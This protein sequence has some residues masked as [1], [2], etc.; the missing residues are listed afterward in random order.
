[1]KNQK[2]KIKNQN[3]K[4]VIASPDLSERSNLMRLLRRFTSRNDSQFSFYYLL[5]TI[6]YL[7]VTSAFGVTTSFWKIT[8]FKECKLENIEIEDGI[9]SPGRKIEPLWDNIEVY[10]WAIFPYKNC[11]YIGTGDE[12]K[13]YKLKDNKTS[14]LFDTKETGVLSLAVFK[15]DI[16]IGTASN[17]IIFK[18]DKNGNS[19]IFKE[20]EQEYI[21][22]IVFDEKGNLY[23][24]TGTQGKILKI[25]R[26][27]KMEVFYETGT[28][29][30][31]FLRYKNGTFYAGT[32]EDGL[33]FKI[34]KTGTGRCIYDA[35]EDEIFGIIPT[36]TAI[37]FAA[38]SD[39]SSSIYKLSKN[40]T[41]EKIWHISTT[42][43]GLTDELLCAADNRLYEIKGLNKDRLIHEFDGEISCLTKNFIGTSKIG[44][45]YKL[46]DSYVKQGTLTSP[47]YEV[48]GVAKWGKLSF[49][50]K[51]DIIFETSSGNIKKSEKTWEQWRKIEEQGNIKS[52]SA[53]FIK[54][55]AT[56]KAK[57]CG[58]KE[59]CVS[60]LPQNE[61]PRI[62]DITITTSE[63]NKG[64][65]NI[66][67]KAQDPNDDKL[68]F[69]LY[70]KSKDSKKW[71]TIK[72][73]ISDTFYLIDKSSF[74][75]GDYYFKVSASD[76]PSNPPEHS[77]TGSKISEPYL[78]DN[79]PPVIKIRKSGK[80][81]YFNVIDK[82]S[83]I[84]SF[85]YSL[86]GAKW[87]LLFP[88][89]GIFDSKQERFEIDISKTTT[90]VI[91]AEDSEGNIAFAREN[92]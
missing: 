44:K 45:L 17:G 49:E 35:P 29:N 69:N 62:E 19:S 50:G 55:R 74:P 33:V 4:F 23:A 37:F 18:I 16:Y 73:E 84:K 21:W 42:I 79:T 90:L 20:T 2:S 81:L 30:C 71:V 78:M 26:T 67:W 59:V 27:G 28:L 40:N 54:W 6:C 72:E 60:Y 14:L 75:D 86:D 24:A 47:A 70:F 76:L 63:K 80:S 12:G 56:L 38:T 1:M 85:H 77:F 52:S 15:N 34:D 25:N 9:C 61:R 22:D 88:I 83:Y 3:Y 7:L 65:R 48:T 36:D 87:N 53:R 46:K 11:I 89:D 13:V 31:S 92:L 64:M 66:T 68:E 41:V 57:G 51:G 8:D 5:F 32:G 43:R 82:L 91:K 39:T 58:L 10:I